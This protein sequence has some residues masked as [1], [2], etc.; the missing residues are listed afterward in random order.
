EKRRSASIIPATRHFA[1]PGPL[2]VFLRSPSPPAGLPTVCRWACKSSRPLDV[3]SRHCKLPLG[4]KRS[5]I[6]SHGAS[7]EAKRRARQAQTFRQLDDGKDTAAQIDHPP[8]VG[9]G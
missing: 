2:W 9:R 8:D 5:S 4:L 3:T 6:G 1:C 7:N